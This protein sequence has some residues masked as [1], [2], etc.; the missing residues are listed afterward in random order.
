MNEDFC[1][2]GRKTSKWSSRSWL[3]AYWKPLVSQSRKVYDERP[4]YRR[5][6]KATRLIYLTQNIVETA[7]DETHKFIKCITWHFLETVKT[8]HIKLPRVFPAPTTKTR[9]IQLCQDCIQG[10]YI[11]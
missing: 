6:W 5:Q 3:I 10:W 8:I 1:P 2:V 11:R 4:C 9:L 7:G